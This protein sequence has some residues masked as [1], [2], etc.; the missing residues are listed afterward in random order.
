MNKRAI[1]KIC[2]LL[3]QENGRATIPVSNKYA[4]IIKVINNPFKQNE[5][6]SVFVNNRYF[7]NDKETLAEM[8]FLSE[9]APIE[10]EADMEFELYEG[11]K[12]VAKGI[13]LFIISE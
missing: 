11:I 6:W 8:C 3:Q 13:V 12:L 2:W 5:S 7:C 9:N 4:P 1:V 10:L